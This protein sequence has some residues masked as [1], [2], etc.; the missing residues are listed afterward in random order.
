[1]AKDDT[2]PQAVASVDLA[3][4]ARFLA[5]D[6]KTVQNYAKKGLVI[7]LG[8]GRYALMQSVANVVT[9]LREQAAGRLGKNE[10]ID[11]A[12][13]NA[14]LKDT[15]R[16]YVKMRIDR[17]K[18]ETISLPEVRS[19]WS[20][21]ALNVKQMFLSLP[22]RA[23]FRITHLTGAD[24]NELDAIVREMLDEVAFMSLDPVLPAASVGLLEDGRAHADA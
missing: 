20:E 24:Q 21:I 5:C 7:R 3:V 16:E 2:K 4:L 19:A 18:G 14:M 12:R 6:H 9:H 10:N 13:A 22:G 17:L 15:Q 11:A 1:M 23:R 8:H